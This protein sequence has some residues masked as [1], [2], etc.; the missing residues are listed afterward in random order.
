MTWGITFV[1]TF[2]SSMDLTSQF[3][4]LP[5]WIQSVHNNFPAFFYNYII[6]RELCVYIY[7]PSLWWYKSEYNPNLNPH[8]DLRAKRV[9]SYP[10]PL[11]DYEQLR[12]KRSRRSLQPNPQS[13]I[14]YFLWWVSRFLLVWWYVPVLV[15]SFGVPAPS[16]GSTMCKHATCCSMVASRATMRDGAETR[17][18]QRH[19]WQFSTGSWFSFKVSPLL[20]LVSWVSYFRVSFC[21]VYK[22]GCRSRT[23]GSFFLLATV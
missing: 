3:S 11:N 12:K 9:L 18:L 16:L 23:A 7:I 19:N 21:L 6:D 1:Y 2:N 15:C 22:R 13:L 10:Q 8:L 17:V 5:L 4:N 20:Y 14:Q